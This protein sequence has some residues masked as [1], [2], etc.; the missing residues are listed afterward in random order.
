[1][2]LIVHKP[3][4][5]HLP[6]SLIDS[7]AA[8]NPH[9]AGLM[10][11][12]ANAPAEIVRCEQT[13]AAVVRAWAAAHRDEECIFH[14][15]YRTRGAVDLENTHPLRVTDDLFLFHNGKVPVDL[16]AAGR[17][18]TWHLVQDLLAPVLT[19]RPEMLRDPVFQRTLEAAI[20]PN[21][22]LVLVDTRRRYV[23]IVN[24]DTGL[25]RDGLWLSNSRW[26]DARQLGWLVSCTTMPLAAN[27]AFLS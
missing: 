5:R 9:G 24:R 19:R 26:F 12:P 17:S 14:F 16:H 22:R 8:F 3:A 23:H 1:M 15:R 27:V 20:G 2:C 7:A 25:E 13:S 18:D 6:P 21:N 10:V 11:L 4:G